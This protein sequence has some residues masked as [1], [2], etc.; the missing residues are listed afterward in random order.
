MENTLPAV[1]RPV[2]EIP[3]ERVGKLRRLLLSQEYVDLRSIYE[4]MFLKE[5]VKYTNTMI[6]EKANS[7]DRIDALRHTF[8]TMLEVEK[9]IAT[10]ESGDNILI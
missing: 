10:T 6:A 1:N 4:N 9:L 2:F 5:G 8:R 7:T 3:H